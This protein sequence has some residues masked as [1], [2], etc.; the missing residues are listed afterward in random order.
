MITDVVV[1][2]TKYQRYSTLDCSTD[3]VTEKYRYM[4]HELDPGTPHVETDGEKITINILSDTNDTEQTQSL[5]ITIN[6]DGSAQ[7]VRSDGE[8]FSYENSPQEIYDVIPDAEDF[9]PTGLA[10]MRYHL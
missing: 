3:K 10:F 2:Y 1:S 4:I 5:Q 6:Q 8:T 9:G 7:G